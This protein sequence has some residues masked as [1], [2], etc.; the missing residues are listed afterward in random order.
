MSKIGVLIGPKFEDIEYT[1]PTDAFKNAGHELNTIGFK[2]GQTVTGKENKTEVTIDKSASDVSTEEYDA[3]F[4]PGGCSPDKLREDENVVKF[5][6]EFVE[7]GKPVLAI[8][9]APQLFITAKVIEGRNVAGWKSII[10]DIEN[11]GGNYVDKEVVEDGNLI[12]SRGPNDI[13]AFIEASLKK[14]G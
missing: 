13:P 11:A 10:V 2:S 3:I 8:C 6:K 1:K 5:T 4:I 9:H 12:T 14:L 7:S